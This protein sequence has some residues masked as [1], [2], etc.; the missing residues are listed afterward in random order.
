MHQ[1]LVWK[2][3]KLVGNLEKMLASDD[4]KETWEAKLMLRAYKN[5]AKYV[6]K[7]RDDNCPA[8]IMLDFSGLLLEN[9]EKLKKELNHIEVN[10]EKIGD[11]IEFYN[12]V[13]KKYPK[14]IEFTGTAYSHC[15]FP[16]TPEKDWEY[17]IEEW[18]N[19][20]EKLFG[21][22]NLKRIKG[23]W[24]PEMGIPGDKNK[25][26]HLIK[27]LK[28]SGYEWMIL[29]LEAVKNE[30]QMGF[31]EKVTKTS[32]PHILKAKDERIPII[33]R[34][35]HDFIDQQAGCDASGVYEK[36]ILASEILKKNDVPALV[37]PASDGENGNTMMNQFFPET[38]EKF[39]KEKID[40]KVSSLTVSKFLK[41]YY[42][43]IESEI[44]LSEEGSSWIGSH[45]NWKEGDKRIEINEKINKL[46]KNFHRIEDKIESIKPDK[47]ALEKYE[48]TKHSL[49]IAE[50]SCYTYWGTEFWFEQARKTLKLLEKKI[51]ELNHLLDRKLYFSEK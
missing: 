46:S 1:P 49:L 31:E 33:F 7:L 15:Y 39:F 2:N 45:K 37:V 34:A 17:Q 11:I 51:D 23:F 32:Q 29:P 8:K 30:R 24:L 27:L 12:K 28:K 21:E 42:P 4:D 18:R 3:G 48:S 10:G 13:M 38:F 16:T 14:S 26:S 22:N 19:V 41:K 25:L 43:K 44:E 36:S 50:T 35:K 6:E 20:Y 9:L 47:K 5:P 40:D